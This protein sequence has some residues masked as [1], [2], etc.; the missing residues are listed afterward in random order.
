M[1]VGNSTKFSGKEGKNYFQVMLTPPALLSSEAAGLRLH[2]TCTTEGSTY[3]KGAKR[4]QKLALHV[5]LTIT[6]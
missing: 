4:N 1:R 5:H 3:L 6:Q 2:H